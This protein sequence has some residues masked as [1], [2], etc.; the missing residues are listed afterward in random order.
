MKKEERL[1]VGL[2]IIDLTLTIVGFITSCLAF[3]LTRV[4]ARYFFYFVAFI[5]GIN[6]IRQIKKIQVKFKKPRIVKYS[7]RLLEKD[8]LKKV[9]F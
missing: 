5:L 6:I 3:C 7:Q 8:V 4:D 1:L 2:D 9:S